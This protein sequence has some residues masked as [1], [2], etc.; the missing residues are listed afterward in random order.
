VGDWIEGLAVAVR[1]LDAE[2]ALEA[3]HDF[4]QIDVV[5]EDFEVL[6][7]VGGAL[8]AS[9]S[10]AR[11][12]GSG[13]RSG[14]GGGGKSGDQAG[15]EYGQTATEE[16]G[17]RVGASGWFRIWRLASKVRDRLHSCQVMVTSGCFLTD[18]LLLPEDAADEVDG[19]YGHGKGRQLAA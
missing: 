2:V 17:H 3:A 8:L 9:T 1:A 14:L 4:A 7:N 13:R 12:W 18:A 10:A 11:G 6:G 15:A 5:G 16:S 19:D